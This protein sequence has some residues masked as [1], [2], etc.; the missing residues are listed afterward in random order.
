[1]QQQENETMQTILGSGGTIG[2]EL[3]RIL[4]QYTDKVRLVSRRPQK[5]IG[6]EELVSADL[7]KP[8]DAMKAVEGSTVAYLT[9]GLPY[10]AKVWEKDW[11]VIMSN[12]ITACEQHHCNLVFFDNIY[13]YDPKYLDQMDENTPMNPASRKGKVRALIAEMMMGEVAKGRLTALIARSADFYGPGLQNSGMVRELVF[14]K[15]A[16]GEKANWM[17]SFQYKHSATYT[18]DAAKAT[19]LLGNTDDAYNQVWHLP[20]A[21]AP[22][23]GK[24]WIE[25]IADEMNLMPET[26]LAPKFL[27]RIMGLFMPLMREMVEMLYQYDRHYV[28][29]SKKFEDRFDMKPTPYLEGIKQ[30]VQRDY[31]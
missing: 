15:I 28:F 14:K 27:V 5:V 19:A 3:A 17:C 25:L 7:T 29:I 8:A 16:A 6:N 18:P 13:M 1:M 23:T 24:E 26:Q 12:V 30:V 10:F 21:A 22:P 31:K 9:V 2:V 20:T 11:P 4:P